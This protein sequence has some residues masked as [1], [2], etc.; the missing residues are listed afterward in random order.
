MLSYMVQGGGRTF[1][2]HQVPYPS[3]TSITKSYKGVGS[4]MLRDGWTE[5]E[6]GYK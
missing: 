5:T 4:F 1:I 2:E 3:M 6:R